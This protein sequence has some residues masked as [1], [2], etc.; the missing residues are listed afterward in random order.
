M[1]G[2]YLNV[3]AGWQ[4]PDQTWLEKINYKAYQTNL[5]F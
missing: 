3:I 5:H 4:Y 1:Y 2:V